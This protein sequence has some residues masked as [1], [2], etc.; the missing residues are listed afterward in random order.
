MKQLDKL[1]NDLKKLGTMPDLRVIMV[2]GS[3]LSKRTAQWVSDQF[4]GKIFIAPDRKS[5]V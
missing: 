5:V 4:D 2:T 3:P 1:L